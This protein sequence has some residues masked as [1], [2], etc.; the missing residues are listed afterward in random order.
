MK[1]QE[2]ERTE[3]KSIVVTEIKKRNHSILPIVMEGK[4]YIGIER[5]MGQFIGVEDSDSG[6][7]ASKQYGLEMRLNQ[8]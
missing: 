2:S 4:I 1:L 7:I 3:F 8:I 6:S 5:L